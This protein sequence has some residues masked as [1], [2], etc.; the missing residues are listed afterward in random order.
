[1]RDALDT[2][3]WIADACD[4]DAQD[5]ARIIPIGEAIEDFEII[6]G[7]NEKAAMAPAA[8]SM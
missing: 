6:Y 3:R 7:Q 2:V 1:M 4:G 8:L 5:K